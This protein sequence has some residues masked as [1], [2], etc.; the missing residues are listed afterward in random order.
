[1]ETEDV[2][3]TAFVVHNGTYEFL[4]MPFGLVNFAAT[5]VRGLRKLLEGLK[6]ANHYMDNIVIHTP[7]LRKHVAALRRV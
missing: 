5:L 1:M 7:T 6:Y 4:I 3:K 2:H